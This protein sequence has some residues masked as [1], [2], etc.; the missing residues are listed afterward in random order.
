[1]E[2]EMK[3]PH[4]HPFNVICY[5][6]WGVIHKMKPSMLFM[7]AEEAS[8]DADFDPYTLDEQDMKEYIHEHLF[9]VEAE[10]QGLLDEYGEDTLFDYYST[11]W[12]DL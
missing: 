4:N 10:N 6:L 11:T 2:N 9:F 5:T 12:N 7:L 1:M 3:Y 8:K